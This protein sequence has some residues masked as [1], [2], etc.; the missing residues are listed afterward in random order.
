[1]VAAITAITPGW[2][3]AARPG[4][5]GPQSGHAPRVEN[6]HRRC[7]R[8]DSPPH[9]RRQA[10]TQGDEPCRTTTRAPHP[11]PEEP[12]LATRRLLAIDFTFPGTEAGPLRQ[13]R[14]PQHGPGASRTA[15]RSISSAPGLCQGGPRPGRPDRRGHQWATP[16]ISFSAIGR[17]LGHPVAIFMPD[18]MSH[19]RINLIRSLGRHHQ[20]GE[21]GRGGVPGQHQPRRGTRRRDRPRLPAPA[22]LQPGQL[23]GPLPDHRP[24]DLVAAPVPRP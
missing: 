17:A 10:H 5:A 2:G 16:A 23:R 4:P 14:E 11:R 18:W 9:S 21:S 22:V 15:W 19:E 8:I 1:V 12:D 24:R 20:P 7:C 6:G 13:G 3:R